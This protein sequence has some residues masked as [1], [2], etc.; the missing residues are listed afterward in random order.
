MVNSCLGSFL[1]LAMFSFYSCTMLAMDPPPQRKVPKIYARENPL[2]YTENHLELE[3]IMLS[4]IGQKIFKWMSS[5]SRNYGELVEFAVDKYFPC[6]AQVPYKDC[7]ILLN[8]ICNYSK[9]K[10]KYINKILERKFLNLAD[11]TPREVAEALTQMQLN[12]FHKIDEENLKIYIENPKKP[13]T[14]AADFILRSNNIVKYLKFLIAYDPNTYISF[15]IKTMKELRELRNASGVFLLYMSL[16]DFLGWFDKYL[17]DADKYLAATYKSLKDICWKEKHSAFSVE[18]MPSL[19]SFDSLLLKIIVPENRLSARDAVTRIYPAQAI[20][21]DYELEANKNLVTFFEGMPKIA[22]KKLYRAFV[23]LERASSKIIRPSVKPFPTWSTEELIAYVVGMGSIDSLRKIFLLGL[24]NGDA[25]DKFL[26]P[27]AH[28]VAVLHNLF[29]IE[30]SEA[31]HLIQIS[32]FK[33]SVSKEIKPSPEIDNLV[34]SE[35]SSSGQALE[36]E[37]EPKDMAQPKL[38]AVTASPQRRSN[39]KRKKSSSVSSTVNNSIGTIFGSGG[40]TNRGRKSTPEKLPEKPKIEEK[41]KDIKSSNRNSAHRQ[42]SPRSKQ[43]ITK[44]EQPVEHLGVQF[45]EREVLMQMGIQFTKTPDPSWQPTKIENSD[46]EDLK[47]D[48]GNFKI[49][50]PTRGGDFEDPDVQLNGFSL[51]PEFLN[52]ENNL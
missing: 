26:A 20:A 41:E 14:P 4:R 37:P 6:R 43:T 30:I 52:G 27:L 21:R 45:V 12:Y 34:L 49:N 39:L 5:S 24:L 36:S 18:G 10:D 40:N 23:A 1:V 3:Q 16:D 19:H 44:T 11:F 13:G 33:P 38:S 51:N 7:G 17:S 46:F 15:F 8:N 48:L 42:R 2:L 35:S 32:N 29:G 9:D 28:R 22:T 31:N 50:P 47:I 25:I